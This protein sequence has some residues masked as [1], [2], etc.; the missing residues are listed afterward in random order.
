MKIKGWIGGWLIFLAGAGMGCHSEQAPLDKDRFTALL[1]EMHR[2]DGGLNVE[3]GM[4]R[5]QEL[6]NYACYNDL[7]RKYGITQAD[8]DSCMYYYSAKN[9]LFSQMY[10]AVVDSL[11]RQLTSI[12]K[13]LNELKA[14]DSVNYFPLPDTLS[15]DSIYTVTVDSI[16]PGLYKFN[17]TLQFDSLNWEVRRLIRSY[18]LSPDAADTLSVRDI[19]VS[20][21]TVRRV[22]H[23]SQ[24]VDSTYSRLV[25]S[26]LLPVPEQRD[27]YVL[28]NRKKEKKPRK[29]IK[30][31]LEDFGGRSW[32]NQLFRPYISSKMEERLRQGL[33]KKKQEE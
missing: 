1:I 21:D 14:K 18:F 32:Q 31:R 5:N 25:I 16:V 11:N 19:F 17:T 9:K 28:S 23:W 24:Y 4:G 33:P 22:Y 8:F 15:L 13:I 2:V 12:D 26:Y 20:M 3:R 29:E 30:V 10:D 7:F 27:G 6:K